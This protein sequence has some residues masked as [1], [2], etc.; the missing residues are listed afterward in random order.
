MLPQQMWGQ[1]IDSLIL[2]IQQADEFFDLTSKKRAYSRLWHLLVW[3]GQKFGRDVDAGRLIDLRL[4][5]QD[6]SE[7]ASCARVTVTYLMQQFEQEG[8]LQRQKKRLILLS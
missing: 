3:L 4:T 2:H 7:V 5:Q 1:A 6:L 8:K